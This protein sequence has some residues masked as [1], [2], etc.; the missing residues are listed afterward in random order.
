M[1]RAEDS[2]CFF[3]FFHE[4]YRSLLVLKGTKI[5]PPDQFFYYYT[6]SNGII[7]TLLRRAKLSELVLYKIDLG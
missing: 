6:I 1:I 5:V 7:F 4:F 2:I 3:S